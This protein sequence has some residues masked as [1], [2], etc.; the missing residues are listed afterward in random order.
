MRIGSQYRLACLR[1][2]GLKFDGERVLDVGCHSDALL[3]SLGAACRVGVDVDPIVD[4]GTPVLVVQADGCRLPLR[5][6]F[7]DH[8]IALDV[9]EHVSRDESLVQEMMRVTRGGGTLF[10]T[11]PSSEIQLFP[12]FITG[13]ISARWGHHRR[14]GYS[15]DRLRKLGSNGCLCKLVEWNAPAYRA[16]YV[17]LR[18]LS[19]VWPWLASRLVDLVARWDARRNEGHHGFYWMRCEK[20]H[21]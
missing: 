11:T 13:W 10:L 17:P 2:Y 16:L 15:P 1:A 14:L 19:A 8:T 12:A 21:G 5:S 20:D 18:V 3:V 9:V 4:K 7:F 6:N